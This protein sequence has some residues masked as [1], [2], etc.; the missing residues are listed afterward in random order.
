MKKLENW[1]VVVSENKL[2]YI[3]SLKIVAS[4]SMLIIAFDRFVIVWCKFFGDFIFRLIKFF[5]MS[6][7][8]CGFK[9]V[10]NMCV[11]F[12]SVLLF[13]FTFVFFVSMVSGVIIW[14]GLMILVLIFFVVF[15]MEVFVVFLIFVLGFVVCM[16]FGFVWIIII[17]GCVG[18]V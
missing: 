16:L 13:E 12:V 17:F 11:I 10:C 8:V 15:L 1:V 5:V 4:V 2:K 6:V 9:E 18:F 14:W 7:V 3:N